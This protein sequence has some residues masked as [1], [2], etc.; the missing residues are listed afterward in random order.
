MPTDTEFVCPCCGHK[1]LRE[2]SV[3][4][5]CSVCWWEDDPLERVE[6]DKWGCC[7]GV[8]LLKAI[9]N[10]NELGEILPGI[11][12]KMNAAMREVSDGNKTLRSLP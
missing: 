8:T 2:E 9:S 3:Y 7:N 10:W 5:I 4:E 12:T 6:P 1:T 11:N